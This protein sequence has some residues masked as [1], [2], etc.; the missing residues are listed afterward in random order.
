VSTTEYIAPSWDEIYAMLLELAGRIRKS[1]F[2]PDWIV[3]VSRG[4]WTPARV[5]SDLLENTNTANMKVEFYTGFGETA[6]RPVVT[7]PVTSGVKGKSILVVD[8]VSDTGESL[9]VIM[10]HLQ[11]NGV[12]QVRTATIFYKPHSVFKPDYY[13]KETSAWIIFPW[14]RLESIR[15]LLEK[16]KKES[17]GVEWV[18]SLLSGLGIDPKVVNQLLDLAG[19]G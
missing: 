11:E 1:N 12:D 16:A 8:D 17:R 5:M 6:K 3:G 15:Q 13:S 14:E 19:A 10:Q 9:K 18:R 4:G 7:Q 2:S